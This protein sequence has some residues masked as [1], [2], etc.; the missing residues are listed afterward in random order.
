MNEAN[1]KN[2]KTIVIVQIS[3]AFG[4]SVS[5]GVTLFKMASNKYPAIKR[6]APIKILVKPF[7]EKLS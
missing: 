3:F 4:D 7:K 5:K 1:R 2:A 6:Y